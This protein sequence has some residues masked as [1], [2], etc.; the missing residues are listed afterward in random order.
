MY[1]SVMNIRKYVWLE[2]GIWLLIIF[3]TAA[4]I[5]I[6]KHKEAK[7]LVTYQIFMPDVDG[8]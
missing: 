1:N 8:Y 7:K 4:G 3:I 5:R 2:F 6:Y